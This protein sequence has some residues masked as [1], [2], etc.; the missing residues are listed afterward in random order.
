M[1]DRNNTRN[2]VIS[3]FSFVII[4]ISFFFLVRSGDYKNFI[5]FILAAFSFTLGYFIKKRH[6][7]FESEN[8]LTEEITSEE[9][10]QRAKGFDL[11]VRT[12]EIPDIKKIPQEFLDEQKRYEKLVLPENKEENKW[13]KKD[14]KIIILN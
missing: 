5:I 10:E 2:H 13:N 11:G 3:F 14:S 12:Q 9:M 1:D 7:G 4:V 6:V 8:P